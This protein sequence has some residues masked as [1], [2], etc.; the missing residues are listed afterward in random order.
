MITT[1]I[2]SLSSTDRKFCRTDIKVQQRNILKILSWCPKEE[3][4]SFSPSPALGNLKEENPFLEVKLLVKK[5]LSAER[6]KLRDAL[7]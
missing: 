4:R 2:I 6:E 5:N 1:I 3:I 7:C